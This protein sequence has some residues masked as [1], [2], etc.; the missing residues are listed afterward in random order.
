MLLGCSRLAFALKDAEDAKEKF[1]KQNQQLSDLEGEVGLLR[2]R[3][4]S[5]ETER[6][7]ERA[8]NKKLQEALNAAR[9]VRTTICH[10]TYIHYIVYGI[11]TQ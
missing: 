5:L 6:D 9:K 8:L 2:R 11:M 3:L 4:G 10:T 1:E 7:K